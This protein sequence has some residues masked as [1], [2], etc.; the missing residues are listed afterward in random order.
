MKYLFGT[1]VDLISPNVILEASPFRKENEFNFSHNLTPNDFFKNLFVDETQTDDQ[2]ILA[3][4]KE[5]DQKIEQRL[6]EIKN[7]NAKVALI[8]I[9]GYA[10]CGKTTFIHHLLWE[11]Y[12][13]THTDSRNYVIDFYGEMRVIDTYTSRISSKIF[14]DINKDKKIIR[15][16]L[17]IN[18]FN[19]NSFGAAT[20]FVLSSVTELYNTSF[21]S[22]FQV[23][24]FIIQ[25]SENRLQ[26]LMTF[27]FL[28]TFIENI[29]QFDFIDG[30]KTRGIYIVYDNVDSISNLGEEKRFVESLKAFVSSCNFFFG[31]NIENQN[32][33]DGV[34]IA[35]IINNLK[36]TCFLTTRII[37]T[38]R[39]QELVPDLETVYGWDSIRMP[40]NYY[41]HLNIFMKR[42]EYFLQQISGDDESEQREKI[43]E[44]NHIHDITEA[45]YKN[46]LFRRLFNTNYRCCIKCILEIARNNSYAGLIQECTDIYS[47]NA[48]DDADGATGILLA[49]VLDYFKGNSVLKEKLHLF[50]D[51]PENSLARIVLNLMREKGGS[52]SYWEVL[53]NLSP[54]FPTELIGRVVYDLSETGR[55]WWRRLIVFR[56]NCPTG[57]KD[58][59][60]QGHIYKNGD[61]DLGKY[62]SL[63]I[64]L[65]GTTFLE[66][67]VPRFEFLLASY[68]IKGKVNNL[69]YQP[70]FAKSSMDIINN[71]AAVGE[72]KYRFESKIKIVLEY[73]RSS[74]C[75]AVNFSKEVMQHYGWTKDKFMEHSFFTFESKERGR[76]YKQSYEARLIFSQVGYIERYRRYIL[77]KT[78]KDEDVLRD[79]NERLVTLLESFLQIYWDENLCFTTKRQDEVARNLLNQINCIKTSQFNDFTTKIEI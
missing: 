10:G 45:F 61:N 29:V 43:Q 42:Y 25:N 16:L 33:F 27:D 72:T 60:N 77:R 2:I 13:D 7:P 70:L 12:L 58:L 79:I 20:D 67:V 57:I 11:R 63:S 24:Q 66:S 15:E 41:S 55:E 26:D 28:W 69:Q 37:T 36:L 75:K 8:H 44:L 9:E 21:E 19:L 46:S 40:E 76:A 30:N 32:E 14:S 62:T 39:L 68:N 3:E 1:P 31:N 64:S 71:K 78:E 4:N 73:I 35:T 53:N 18:K 65:A 48:S 50:E 23:R 22:E 49:L 54:F 56:E 5:F 74:C 52:C 59:D 38:R 6:E 51:E 17:C 47:S 34:K